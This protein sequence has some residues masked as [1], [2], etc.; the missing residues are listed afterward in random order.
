MALS[1]GSAKAPTHARPVSSTLR[2]PFSRQHVGPF[3]GT[4]SFPQ[5]VGAHCEPARQGFSSPDLSG[6]QLVKSG[7]SQ[8]PALHVPP[9]EQPP[10]R[11]QD[12]PSSLGEMTHSP[13][14]GSQDAVEH[15]SGAWQAIG[16]PPPHAPSWQVVCSVQSCPS[17]QGIPL[18]TGV[19]AHSPSS[20]SQKPWRHASSS[21]SHT[22][23]SP[24][25]Q[26]PAK[27]LSFWVQSSPSSHGVPA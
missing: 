13:V 26:T 23:L 11:M 9:V 3:F 8:M 20:G 18:G 6:S 22:R 27:Q 7:C 10:A 5:A 12:V 15:A 1:T 19:V 4:H 24:E 21:S 17:S 25:M 16:M 2:I 14:S